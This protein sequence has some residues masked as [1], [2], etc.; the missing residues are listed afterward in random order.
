MAEALRSI[1]GGCR[2]LVLLLLMLMVLAAL[3]EEAPFMASAARVL[4]QIP[5]YGCYG[6]Q[7]YCPPPYAP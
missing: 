2:Q 6:S 1:P 5:T 4:L 7:Y 3:H